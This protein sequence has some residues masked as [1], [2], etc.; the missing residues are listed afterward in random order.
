ML[1][2]EDRCSQVA[3]EVR[4]IEKFLWQESTVAI[5]TSGEPF[6]LIR[7]CECSVGAHSNAIPV[8]IPEER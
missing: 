2:E 1:V 7:Y 8:Q 5:S 3:A 4:M 6:M